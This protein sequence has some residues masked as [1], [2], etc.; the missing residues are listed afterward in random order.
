[1]ILPI[2]RLITP[3]VADIISSLI[4]Y[5]HAV[6]EYLHCGINFISQLI[7]LGEYLCTNCGYVYVIIHACMQCYT[8]WIG[9]ELFLI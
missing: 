2:L 1:M 8:Y 4:V 7:L 3:L 5:Y 9:R 6:L